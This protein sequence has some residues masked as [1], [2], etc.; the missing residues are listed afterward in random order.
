MEFGPEPHREDKPAPA[1][2]ERPET[3]TPAEEQQPGARHNP[4]LNPRAALALQ[5]RAGNRAVS[6][7]VAQR[8]KAA[9]PAPPAPKAPAAPPQ[10]VTAS[11][12]SGAALADAAAPVEAIAVQRLASAPAPASARPS[13]SAQDPK[14]N[15]LK[16][17]V[18]TKKGTLAK[19]PPPANEAAAAAKAA[20]PP[21]DD[22]LAQGKAANAEKMNDAKP[23]EFDKAAFVAAV[24][25][26]IARQAPKNLEEADDF[27][28]SGKADAVKDQVQGKVGDGKKQSASAIES[29]TKAPP[30]TGAAKDKPVT[31]LA[32]DKP[33]PR[34]GA[35]DP[36]MAVPDKAPPAATDFS[37]GPKSVDQEMASAEVTEEQLATSNEPEFT[38]ALKDKKEGEAHSATAPGEVRAKE[39]ATLNAA[40]A[41]ALQEGATAM[42]SMSVARNKSGQD[43]TSG[44]GKAQSADEVKRAQ[45]TAKLQTVFDATKTDV[46]KILGDLDKKVDDKFTKDEKVARDA[47]TSDHKRRMDAYKDKRYSGWSGGL[48]WAKDKLMGMPAEANDI[49]AVSRKGYVASMQQVISGVADLIGTELN[50]AKTRI[51]KGRTD[52]KAEVDKLPKDLQSI[53]KEAAG[54][55]AGKFDELTES[56]DNKGTELVDTLASKYNDALKSVDEEIAAEKEKN[57]GLVAKAMDAVA[58]VIKTILELKNLLLGILAKAASAI[59]GIIKD[60]IGFLG[61]LISAIGSGIQSF[62]ANITGHLKKGMLS[63]LLGAA[64]KAGLQLPEKFDLRGILMMIASL[65][66]LTWGSIKG[67]VIAKGVPAAAMTA[68]ESSVPLAQKIAGGGI[69]AI[70]EDIKEQ[71]GDLK[72]NL[73]GKIAEYLI[74]TVLIAGVTWILSLLNPA[75]A[76]I[77]ACKAII[78]IVTFIVTRGAQ[79]A[80]FVNAVLDS[81]IAIAKGGAGGVGALIENALAKSI[82]VLIGFLAALLGVGGIADK[83]KKF[84]AALS[85]PVMKAV[86]WV[87]GKIAGFGK[88]IWAKMRGKSGKDAEGKD[89]KDPAAAGELHL[90]KSTDMAGHGHTVY[91]DVKNGKVRLEMASQRRQWIGGLVTTALGKAR[92]MGEPKLLE[93]LNAIDKQIKAFEKAEAGPLTQAKKDKIEAQ[94][95]EITNALNVIGHMFKMKDLTDFTKSKYTANGKLLDQYRNGKAIRA[96]FYPGWN[97]AANAEKR[98]QLKDHRDRLTRE[99]AAFDPTGALAKDSNNYVCPGNG[100][101][102]AHVADKS[103]ESGLP[104][105]DHVHEVSSQWNDEGHNTPHAPRETWYNT[106][107][108]HSTMCTSCNGSKSGPNYNLDVGPDFRGP[109]DSP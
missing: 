56:V 6:R 55:F 33:P 53:G 10:A 34:P 88:K 46:E 71:V 50:A 104:A 30:D 78:D 102:A 40:K 79:I 82:P 23:G 32:P 87:V 66:G 1:H 64:A 18:V 65:V 85:K 60:P 38:G 16:K 11:G 109:G 97:S 39:N 99:K 8:T 94:L 13:S 73:F 72:E 35:P 26:A 42:S 12:G 15:A 29:T 83:V 47:F 107:S 84:F 81:V 75:S 86:D 2:R 7:M 80:E 48:K 90:D 4:G 27:G 95:I 5:S 19:H 44:K 103:T 22:K 52:L 76:F 3:R 91:A 106:I 37:E 92:G 57:K 24:N 101:R 43:L 89:K 93:Y 108:N 36:A 98:R 69:G 100:T 51:A 63:W 54:E 62:M 96:N 14:F 17:D 49:F 68:V 20:K 105:I 9:K 58:G 61:N 28:G 77:K 41:D 59:A 74:P 70:T 25:E 31:P 45:V 21:A 67:R